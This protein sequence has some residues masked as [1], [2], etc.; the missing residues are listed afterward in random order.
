MD[1]LVVVIYDRL[2]SPRQ[3]S[4]KYSRPS[5]WYMCPGLKG[6]DLEITDRGGGGELQKGMRH[7]C[8]F[9]PTKRRGVEK[10]L[11]KAEEGARQVLR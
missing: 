5:S 11:S 6:T 4:L 3:S 2:F 8:S 10:R 7:K 1:Q 9:T